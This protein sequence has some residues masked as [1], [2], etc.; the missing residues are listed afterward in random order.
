MSVFGGLLFTTVG[1]NLQAK[2]QA[3]AQLNFTRIA[4]GDGDL[5]GTSIADLTTLKHQIKSLS[6]TKLKTMAGGNAVVGTAFSNQDVTEGF[7]W[8]ELGVYAQDPDLGEVLYCY[9]NADASAEY[10][11]SS[12]G[13]DILEKSIDVVTIIGNAS[14]VSATIDTSLT[15]T[16]IQDFNSHTGNNV[17]HVSQTDRDTWNAKETPVG[18][19]TKA[20]AAEANSKVYTDL[21]IASIPAADPGIPS[22]AIVMW[23]GSIASIPSGWAICN[24]ANGTPNLV[25][26]FIVGAGSTYNMGSTGG[27]S[28]NDI[29]HTHTA[30]GSSGYAGSHSH[31]YSSA[32]GSPSDTHGGDAGAQDYFASTSHTHSVSGTTNSDGSHNHSVSVTVNSGGVT[33]LENRPLYY[34][35]AYIMK[36]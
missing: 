23:S 27:T 32:T 35:L 28:T 33:T 26:R 1:R 20:N 8:K 15:F 21:Q 10:I 14:N 6:I 9:G 7:Y 22:G 36:L 5:G 3:G 12:G 31:S 2:A 29:S 25:N 16:T 13:A 18:A 17:I 34:A 19:Q 4:I 24:G 11:P 30:S